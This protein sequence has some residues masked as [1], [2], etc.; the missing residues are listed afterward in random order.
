MKII[1]E[2]FDDISFKIGPEKNIRKEYLYRII[3]RFYKLAGLEKNFIFKNLIIPNDKLDH[4][5]KNAL[6][7]I[8]VIEYVKL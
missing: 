6:L 7:N 3:K 1:D 4:E 2:I 5:L 8:K